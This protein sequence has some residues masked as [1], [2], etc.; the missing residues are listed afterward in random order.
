MWTCSCILSDLSCP[1]SLPGGIFLLSNES[2][3]HFQ[4]LYRKNLIY[5]GQKKH[6][7]KANISWNIH[8]WEIHFILSMFSFVPFSKCTTWM[9]D[10]NSVVHLNHTMRFCVNWS[11]INPFGTYCQVYLS[12]LQ[13]SKC[14][15]SS[16]GDKYF[17]ALHMHLSFKFAHHTRHLRSAPK[18]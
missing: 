14:Q 2:A 16:T 7:Y 17:T 1:L 13:C 6:D 5:S 12:R 4:L 9:T 10:A 3:G 18:Y 8:T 15:L 11:I